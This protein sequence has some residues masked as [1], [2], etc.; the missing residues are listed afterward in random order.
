MGTRF[1][2]TPDGKKTNVKHGHGGGLGAAPDPRHPGIFLIG[3]AKP[4]CGARA[5]STGTPKSTFLKKMAQQPVGFQGGGSGRWLT[6]RGGPAG[7]VF[8]G[9]RGNGPSGPVR[10]EKKL[11]HAT[12]HQSFMGYQKGAPRLAGRYVQ[13]LWGGT[14][15]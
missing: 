11:Y 7:G 2:Q 6:G 12:P 13:N 3:T 15:D 14:P 10:G 8:T 5:P 9:F 1:W 4:T